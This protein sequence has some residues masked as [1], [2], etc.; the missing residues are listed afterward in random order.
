[1]N[2]RFWALVLLSY[3]GTVLLVNDA[4]PN[5]INP[6]RPRE[7]TTTTVSCYERSGGLEHKIFRARI[8][9]GEESSDVLTFRIGE[10]TQQIPIADIESVLLSTAPVDRNGFAN[11]ALVRR[12]ESAE[13]SAAVQVRSKGSALRLSG[14]T[15]S[16][17]RINLELGKCSRIEFSTAATGEGEQGYKPKVKKK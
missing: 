16:G 3:C 11:A 1:M 13:E 12:D 17:A 15:S 10:A 6:P 8:A 9:V 5:G 7:S 14:F 2:I 4:S